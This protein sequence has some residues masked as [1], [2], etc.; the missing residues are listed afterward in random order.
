MVGA[1][2]RGVVSESGPYE[3]TVR[4][5]HY[6]TDTLS[7]GELQMPFNWANKQAV[8]YPDGLS[9]EQ[10]PLYLLYTSESACVQSEIDKCCTW[11]D[12]ADNKGNPLHADYDRNVVSASSGAA[13]HNCSAAIDKC[14]VEAISNDISSIHIEGEIFS[15]P[16][17]IKIGH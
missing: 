13:A 10:E 1:R 9:N 12:F 11:D 14:I 16:I 2:T 6:E 3:E 17:V 5:N 7:V 8:G 15:S 4:S